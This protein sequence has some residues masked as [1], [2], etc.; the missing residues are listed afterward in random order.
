[1]SDLMER[2]LVAQVHEALRRVYDPCSLANGNPVNVLDMGLV[3]QCEVT[4]PGEI[5]V[6]FCV[7]SVSCT[8]APHFLGAAERE[9]SKIAGITKVNTRVDASVLWTEEMMAPY[10]RQRIGARRRAL[11]QALEAKRQITAHPNEAPSASI[12]QP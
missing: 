3:R 6:I 9:V 12:S 10:L 8:M 4:G 5:E 2:T 11:L 7:T 1:M